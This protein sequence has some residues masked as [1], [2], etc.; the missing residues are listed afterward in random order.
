MR[1][2]HDPLL[3]VRAVNQH[4]I[5]R[6]SAIRNRWRAILK[7]VLIAL[8]ALAILFAGSGLA[9]FAGVANARPSCGPHAVNRPDR[10][11][12]DD[13]WPPIDL[14][15]YAMPNYETV[16][17]PSRQPGI[18]I[19]GWWVPGDPG[20]PAVILVHGLGACK[21]AID[22]LV[23]A[24]M[25]SR[26]GFSVLMIDVRD[27]GDSGTEDGWISAGNEEYLDVLGA[28]DWLITK[29]GFGPGRIGLYGGSVGGATA[30]YA[31]SHEPRVAALFLHS[32]FASLLAAFADILTS[33]GLPGFLAYPTAAMGRL[34]SGEDLLEHRPADVIK[35]VGNRPIYIVHSR[36]DRRISIRQSQEL[37]NAAQAAGV[38]VAT[39][40][41]ENG[42]HLQTPAAYPQEFEQRLVGFFRE[43][44]GE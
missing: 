41:P 24:G 6:S 12:F 9:L 29:K 34:V 1:Q 8:L 44:L 39:W 42:L 15:L 40:F 38:S 36:G 31:F 30:L 11:V 7:V 33:Y 4:D 21:N 20:A 2:G 14:S 26:N 23:P 43:N 25:L 17:F 28:W 18:E 27:V 32:T 19:A 10:I 22:V 16:R 37:A 13:G 5:E 35:E 3:W